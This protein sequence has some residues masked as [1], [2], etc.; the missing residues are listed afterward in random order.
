MVL[1]SANQNFQEVFPMGLSVHNQQEIYIHG[2]N[3]SDLQKAIEYCY[4]GEISIGTANVD[5]LSKAATKLQFT[6]L[7]E[8]CYQFYSTSTPCVSNCLLVWKMAELKN[9]AHAIALKHF[10]E[11]STSEEF[12]RLDADQL[13]ALINDDELIVPT[14]RSVFYAVMKWVKHDTDNRKESLGS[15]LECVRFK[16]V[17][18][19]VSK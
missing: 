1:Y 13:S 19:S 8:N 17:R 4:S 16:H 5:E 15:L 12:L 3:G 9:A 6:E 7:Q 14:E 18:S 11:V 2:V 10:M